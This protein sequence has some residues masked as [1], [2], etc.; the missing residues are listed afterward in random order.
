MASVKLEKYMY[1]QRQVDELVNYIMGDVMKKPRLVLL[2]EVKV[3]NRAKRRVATPVQ[4]VKK[5]LNKRE[6][7]FGPEKIKIVCVDEHCITQMCSDCASYYEYR[8][9]WE[10]DINAGKKILN[11][12]LVHEGILRKMNIPNPDKIQLSKVK[13]YYL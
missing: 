1:V 12:R 10:R 2:A 11:I 6:K 8:T 9:T 7:L 13:S 4:L 3:S 5:L